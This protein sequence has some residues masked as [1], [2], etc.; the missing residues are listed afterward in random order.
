MTNDTSRHAI[1]LLKSGSAIYS[2]QK[3]FKPLTNPLIQMIPKVR[4]SS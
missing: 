3:A 4:L 1:F 2:E